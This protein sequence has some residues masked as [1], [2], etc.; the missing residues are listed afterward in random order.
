MIEADPQE[1]KET[2]RYAWRVLAVVCL[3][4]L[5]GGLNQS[6]LN[7]ALP[8]IVR[9]FDASAFEANWVLLSY[10]LTNTVLMIFFGRLADVFGRQGMYLTG[11]VIFT[12]ASVVAGF[13]PSIWFLIGCRIVQAAAGAMLITN[14]AALVTSAFPR[15][16]MG[17]GLGIYMSSFSLAQLLGPTIGGVLTTEFGWEWS[18]WF[19]VPLGVICFVWGRRVLTRPPRT[20]QPLRLDLMG[21]FTLLIGLGMLLLAL[22]EVGNLGWG[23]PLVIVGLV[24]F[25]IAIP[26]FL[27]IERRTKYPVVDLAT[28][29]DPVVGVGVL[30]GFLA[31]MSRFAVVILMGLYFE[32]AEG[33]SPTGAGLKILPLAGA[34]IIA[35]P[36]VGLMLRRTSPRSVAIGSSVVTSV[37]LVFLL[38]TISPTTPYW[39]LAIG[40]V[41]MGLGSG[42][43]IPANTTAMLIDV[44]PERLGITNAVRITAQSSGVV[45]STALVLT[46][47]STPLPRELREAVFKGTLSQIPGGGVADLVAGYRWAFGLMLVMSLL[48]LL[49]STVGKHRSTTDSTTESPDPVA[50]ETEK[51]SEWERSKAK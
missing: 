36:T 12:I 50:R 16:M 19:N 23:G 15:R 32:A 30:A 14:S 20:P 31:T 41:V 39:I 46:I 5:M 44:P 43:F 28:F 13:S 9:H 4:S 38:V 34:A 18:F 10:M 24:V 7:V 37:G 8:R 26:T 29:R 25:L 2:I 42:S 17:Q 11:I 22:S 51:E 47:I 6:S 3:A 1:S 27:T 21:N 40:M 35:S 48:C 33:D 45:I 49:A